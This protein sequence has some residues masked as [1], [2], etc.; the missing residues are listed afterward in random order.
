MSEAPFDPD[1]DSTPGGDPA[2]WQRLSEEISQRERRSWLSV[3]RADQRR[4]WSR[5]ERT[6]A[7]LYFARFPAVADD[8]ELAVD[9][10]YSEALLRAALGERPTAQ[11]YA[12]RF[13]QH[14]DELRRQFLLFEALHAPPPTAVPSAASSNGAT[15]PT[16][17]GGVVSPS[18]PSSAAGGGQGGGSAWP[19]VSGYEI[20]GE[21]GHGG[22]GIVYQARETA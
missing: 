17:A 12:A 9:L 6:G 11:E 2:S 14:A 4:R 16:V 22:M 19:V 5:G 3:L 8:A 20:L 13:P 18:Q 7:E 21:L 1:R 10:I 15:T